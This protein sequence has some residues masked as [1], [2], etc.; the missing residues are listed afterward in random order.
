MR[1]FTTGRA[2]SGR[3]RR[4]QRQPFSFNAPAEVLEGRQL[5]AGGVALGTPYL[6]WVTQPSNA[7]AGHGL[8]S[9]TVDVMINRKVENT[10]ISV[11]DTAFNGLYNLTAN[12]P[13]V[14]VAPS[15]STFLTPNQPISWFVG[16]SNGVGNYL[17]KFNEA[18]LDV[19][20]TY[21]LTA[22]TPAGEGNPVVAGNAVSSKF[23]VLS[24]HGHRPS[25]V[26]P[27]VRLRRVSHQSLG[28]G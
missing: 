2:A 7:I 19:A 27:C 20:G 12:G 5:L 28:V 13:G 16:I 6:A 9:F 23:T 8:S 11:I 4:G 22:F 26:R 10:T 25:R 15:N 18:A 3:R 17:A 24:G 21:T 1:R 14:I